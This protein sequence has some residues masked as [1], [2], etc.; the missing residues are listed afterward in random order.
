[1]SLKPVIIDTDPGDDDATSILWALASGKVDVL[2][3]SIT[4]G[5][6]GV[7]KC[8]VNALRALEVA[9]RSDIPVFKG[10]YRPLIRQVID[11]EWIHGKDGLG[12]VEG[13]PFPITSPAEGFSP[14]K[15]AE[16][17]RKSPEPVT[18]LA[19]GPL[20]NIALA[21]MADREFSKNVKEVIFMGGAYR[22]SGNTSPRASYNVFV[23]PEAAHVVYSSGIPIIQIGLDVCDQVTQTVEDLN[24]IAM[25]GT[26][27]S[28][29]LMKILD[30]R[31]TKAALMIKNDKGEV[32]GQI[33]ASEQVKSRKDGIGLN[34][35]TTT[36][37]LI[38][39][40]WFDTDHVAMNVEYS[41]V[42]TT[43]ETI[44]D[45]M[46]LWGK[47]PNGYFAHSV[48]GKELVDQWVCDMKSYK[49]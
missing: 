31:R 14:V 44:I 28:E 23:D 40:E 22:V 9:G 11:A 46:G 6:V 41:G 18:I 30:F 38:N 32:V 29:W 26:K 16:I 33:K 27:V 37:Y 4:N 15:I 24:S 20:T 1:M 19:L 42:Y 7:D 8:V 34:D 3:L 39:P 25:A 17:V 49:K 36:G 35:L 45:H 48:R 5:N 12:D 43:G 21:I 10:A 47:K 13:L 2:A